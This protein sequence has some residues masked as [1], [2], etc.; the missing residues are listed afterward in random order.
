M[1]LELYLAFVAA[2]TIMILMPGPSVLLTVAHAMTFG[3][4]RALL[5]VAGTSTAIVLQLAVTALGMTSLLLV[6]SEWFE[7]LRWAG[8]AYLVYLGAQLWR[9]QPC[10]ELA[11]GRLG[12]SRGTLFWQGFVV[13]ATNPKSL[14]FYA[15][16][17]PQFVDPDASPAPQL[18]LLCGSFF[19]IA[20]ALTAGYALLAERA[21]RWFR[22]RRG[23]L[24]RNRI[25]GT[26]MIG[27]GLGLALARRV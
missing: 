21:G 13:S 23:H 5:T 20:T 17:F 3:G 7:V 11:D 22:G 16:F 8:V 2:T 19:I 18:A 26:L 25:T 1:T 4:R 14:F 27:A 24:V 10:D 9:A 6:L 15:A 12:A